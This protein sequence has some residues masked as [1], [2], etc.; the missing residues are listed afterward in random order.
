MAYCVTQ[1]DILSLRADAAAVSVEIS[2]EISPFPVCLAVAEAGGE[3]LRA[4]IREKRF[5]PVGS[6]VE[7]DRCAL[8]FAH[9]FAAAAPIWLTGKANELLALHRTYQSLFDAAEAA[10]CQSLAMPF[11]SALRYRF[12]RD[13]AIR[14]AFAEAEKTALKVIFAADTPELYAQ[15]RKPYRKP[16]IVS[17]VGWYRDHAIFELDNGSFA[18]I[19]IRPEITDVTPIPYFEA[20]YRTGNNP[21]Q[22]PLPEAEIKRLRRIYEENDW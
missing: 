22:P 6:A 18:R 4:A 13:E 12:P 7:V 19:D 16:K 5:L 3:A 11:L 8:P 14:I 1:E 17:Y 15:S 20:C 10:G 2:L 9:L 21:L